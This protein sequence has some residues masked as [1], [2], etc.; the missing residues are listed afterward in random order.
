M[1]NFD[2]E[3]PRKQV[4]FP[5]WSLD[6]V[7]KYLASDVFE[8][9]EHTDFMSLTLKTVFLIALATAFRVSELHALSVAADCC[10]H[11]VD[12]S[13]T[14]QTCPGFVAKN[15]LPSAATQVVVIHPLDTDCL[16]CPVRALHRYIE[17]SASRRGSNLQLFVSAKRPTAKTS[18]QLL[19]SY[20]K[21]TVV[22]AYEWTASQ[23]STRPEESS[24][25]QGPDHAV[26]EDRSA[27]FT[28]SILSSQRQVTGWHS[29]V[30]EEHSEDQTTGRSGSCS[31]DNTWTALP[32]HPVRSA[33][34]LA[35]ECR[36]VAASLAF[37]RGVPLDE[38]LRAVGWSSR[39]TFARFYLRHL[40]S[41]QRS[42]DVELRLPRSQV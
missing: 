14:L 6:I 11:N 19:S 4:L 7:L 21:S 1:S 22:R 16:Y 33:G 28:P 26:N 12:G 25:G 40:T 41:A 17:V 15:R 8:P 24:R 29:G 18:P 32:S 42:G 5:K 37:L 23:T 9:L 3:R 39:N 2:I 38:L 10:R 30:A 36:A 20:I 34:R 35:H 13:Y 31:D 27:S